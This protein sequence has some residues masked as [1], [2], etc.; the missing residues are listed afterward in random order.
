MA[1]GNDYYFCCNSCVGKFR[2]DP[3][4]Y[5]SCS[6]EVAVRQSPDELTVYICPMCPGVREETP[7]PCP[8][9][10]MALEPL[11]IV[12]EEVPKTRHSGLAT[13]LHIDIVVPYI[14]SF[15]SEDR[16]RN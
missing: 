7:I 2:G 8:R 6:V 4:S 11:N 10:G 12:A 14:T 16:K 15:G 3:A 1:D 9:C 5:V 13:P